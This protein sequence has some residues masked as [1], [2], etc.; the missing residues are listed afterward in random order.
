MSDA[1]GSGVPAKK[2]RLI[3]TDLDGT[4]LRSDDTVSA[5]TRAAL[6][7]AEAAGLVIV[8]VTGRP[9]RWLDDVVDETGHTGVAVGANGAVIY[10]L[11]T[12][13]VVAAHT[14]DVAATRELAHDIRCAFPDVAFAV[15]SLGGF[16]AE[17]DYVH[18][19]TINP[20]LDRHG[21]RVPDPATGDLRTIS[22]AP[23]LKLLA[24]DR[25][26]DVDDFL[27]A[28][29]AVL[30]GRA[31]VTH[32]SSFGL[33]EVAAPGVSKAT[34]LAEVAATHGISRDEIVAIGDMPNDVPMLQWA[35]TSYAVANAHPAARL[36]ADRVIA[37]NDD[38]AVAG[39]IETVLARL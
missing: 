12:E 13:R 28:A 6:E 9:V 11:C 30:A 19:W 25:G 18:D 3:A 4:L 36:A 27:D 32:S 16:A 23:A 37:G 7:A 24:K 33:I 15:E 14:L 21:R 10:D 8:F 20:R 29:T 34:G 5:R 2:I 17:P 39:V 22:A 35:G 31:S 26:A 38:D 1:C